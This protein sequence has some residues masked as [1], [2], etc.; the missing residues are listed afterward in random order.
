[1]LSERLRSLNIELPHL[2]PKGTYSLATR[3]DGH[4]SVSGQGPIGPDGSMLTGAVGT[5]VSVEDAR[6]G[7]RVT[8]INLLA[9][10][11]SAVPDID[12]IVGVVSL[13]VY[14]RVGGDGVELIRIADGCSD[15]FKELF[16][17]EG[18][19][20]RAAIGVASLPFGLALEATAV[21]RTV[22]RATAVPVRI[23]AMNKDHDA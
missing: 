3:L 19:P 22:A 13:T 9:A 12:D 4:V 21:F 2:S 20:A 1:M 10:A 17:E 11:R 16:G 14:V 8:A 23:P 5:D 7:A 15:L 6:E 18:L